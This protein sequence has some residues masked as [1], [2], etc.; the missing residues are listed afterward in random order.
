M[1]RDHNRFWYFLKKAPFVFPAAPPGA[2]A[3][4]VA[5]EGLTAFYAARWKAAGP[6]R[7][8]SWRLLRAAFLLWL[9][10][11]ARTLAKAHGIGPERR[12]EIEALCRRRFLDPRDAIVQ[13]LRSDAEAALYVR[14]FEEAA[15]SRRLNPQYWDGTC[16]MDDKAEFAARCVRHGLPHPPLRAL[17]LRGRVEARAL[18]EAPELFLKPR[19]GTGGFGV[20]V[21]PAAGVADLAGL[22]AR[23]A[24]EAGTRTDWIAQDRLRSHPDLA[25][26]AL[27]ALSTVR[28]NTILDE[29]G[30]AEVVSVALKLATVPGAL[31]DNGAGGGIHIGVEPGTGRLGVGAGRAQSRMHERNPANG[32]LFRGRA[33]PRFAE[34]VAQAIRAHETAFADYSYVGWDL[35]PTAERVWLIEGNAKASMVA[36]QRPH[37]RWMKPERFNALLAMHIA[38]GGARG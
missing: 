32:V 17:C 23:L 30:R 3:P 34:I 31:A 8:A 5:A 20:G 25:D 1:I 9:P 13:N 29:A 36:A 6:L 10:G 33:L 26:A 21:C 18:P 22:A 37:L 11:R 12:A 2:P 24:R 19:F 35:A 38:K 7:R 15:I 16:A 28:V 27:D 4:F 14:R